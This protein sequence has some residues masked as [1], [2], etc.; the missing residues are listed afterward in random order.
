M[1]KIVLLCLIVFSSINIW[2]Q[3]NYQIDSIISINIPSKD[4]KIDSLQNEKNKIQ[5]Q[6]KLGNSEF[7]VEKELFENDSISIYHS[8]L[9]YD[10]KS[11]EKY[12]V[13]LSE[14]Y[15]KNSTYNLESENLILKNNFKGYHLK[16]TDTENNNIYELKYFLF[17]K[18]L[19]LFSYK[20]TVD[21]NKNEKDIFFNSIK[22]K[23]S[24]YIT[25]ISGK[26]PSYKS[27]YN[28]GY[29]IGSTFKKHSSTFMI[30]GGLILILIIG[31]IVYFVRRK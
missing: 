2:S 16:L 5:F 12:Y 25:Q 10:T 19:Y 1:K 23:E 26:S 22:I 4:I 24:K 29:K 27:G 9:P 18:H 15:V 28:V 31:I 30:L 8:E 11:L 14:N 3:N 13:T 7:L 21:F 20:N 6:S 17:N